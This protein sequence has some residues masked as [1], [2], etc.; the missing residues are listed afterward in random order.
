MKINNPLGAVWCIIVKS[1]RGGCELCRL[2][3]SCMLLL[4]LYWGGEV[5][6]IWGWYNSSEVTGDLMSGTWHWNVLCAN[7]ILPMQIYWK[8]E[9]SAGLET[10][11]SSLTVMEIAASNRSSDALRCV[12]FDQCLNWPFVLWKKF[13]EAARA[14]Q[15]RVGGVISLRLLLM[16]CKKGRNLN[17]TYWA[18]FMI[19]LYWTIRHQ[20]EICGQRTLR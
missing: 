1:R 15:Q 5:I 4:S 20:K 2:P 16:R 19:Y 8:L 13:T 12:Y 9:E 7:T 10:C 18:Q 14:L 3:L 17:V 6:L 11:S